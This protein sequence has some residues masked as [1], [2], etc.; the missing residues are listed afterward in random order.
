MTLSVKKILDLN[1]CSCFKGEIPDTVHQCWAGE[2]CSLPGNSREGRY[3][4]SWNHP[5]GENED[6]Y[7]L[8]DE[9]DDYES[10]DV[11]EEENDEGGDL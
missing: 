10:D 2:D 3:W 5:G 8:E 4:G 9:E 11:K 6:M 1:K 7:F